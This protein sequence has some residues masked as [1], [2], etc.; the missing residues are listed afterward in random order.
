MKVNQLKILSILMLTLFVATTMS[1][2]V[3]LPS[4]FSDNMVLQRGVELKIFGDGVANEQV[5]IQFNGQERT[6]WPDEKTGKW[7]AKLMPMKATSYPRDLTIKTKSGT[8]IIKNVL[9]GDVWFCFGEESGWSS[10]GRLPES[11]AIK[12]KGEKSQVRIFD[13]KPQ[14]M[15]TPQA[16][17]FLT[18][19]W[20]NTSAKDAS[21]I[22]ATAYLFAKAL[23]DKL[24]IPI[25]VINAKFAGSS[26]QSWIS[27]D[28]F[29]KD[30]MGK[31][32]FARW[33]LKE[34]QYAQKSIKWKK[35]FVKWEKNKS[36]AKS[37]NRRYMRRSP[38]KPLGAPNSPLKTAGLHNSVIAPLQGVRIKGILWS[39]GPADSKRTKEYAAALDLFVKSSR[40]FWNDDSLPIIFELLPPSGRK[41]KRAIESRQS[42]AYIRNKQ[43]AC[44]DNN[45][46]VFVVS[47]FDLGW[48]NGLS[49]F[50]LAR[51][52]ATTALV[53]IGEGTESSSPIVAKVLGDAK[54]IHITFSNISGPLF[55]REKRRFIGDYSSLIGKTIKIIR[56]GKKRKRITPIESKSGERRIVRA[57]VDLYDKKGKVIKHLKTVWDKAYVDPVRNFCVAETKL[58]LEEQKNW[59][60]RCAKLAE[61]RKKKAEEKK[62]RKEVIKKQMEENGQMPAP[63]PIPEKPKELKPTFPVKKT[64]LPK[65][66]IVKTTLYMLNSKKAI[67]FAFSGEKTPL[68]WAVAKIKGDEIMIALKGN[69]SIIRVRYAYGNNP[70]A[71]LFSENGMPVLPFDKKVSQRKNS[72]E[73]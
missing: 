13:M 40:K 67:G 34:L 28:A 42:I 52:I 60:K 32:L 20:R 35:A 56:K 46:R 5:T 43:L 47:T 31:M 50:D 59:K 66:K 73:E 15:D 18:G 10:L 38:E 24:K 9:V 2:G 68:T 70:I 22:S 69:D 26:I 55:G 36:D 8:F 1:S 6:V 72:S 45:N 65:K 27:M 30:R 23:H 7:S 53:A 71:S 19:R 16:S 29:K 64:Q 21:K 58:T 57:D 41:Q 17:M 33:K 39:Q 11:W 48:A 63:P 37:K 51:R 62:K 25:G 49:Q 12:L 54:N 44:S 61:E 4:F 3:L 14:V